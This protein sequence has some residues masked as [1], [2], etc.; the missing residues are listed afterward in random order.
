[1]TATDDYGPGLLAPYR[2][3][4]LTDGRGLL[5]GKMLADL[6]ADVVQVEPPGGSPARNVGPFY[7]DNPGAERSLF[8]WAYCANKPRH[9]PR[10]RHRRRGRP[11][12]PPSRQRRLSNRVRA[13]PDGWHR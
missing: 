4:D 2:V 1:M 6:G 10:H 3:L 8:W 9:Y 13:I 7:H 11:A 5:C 12:A